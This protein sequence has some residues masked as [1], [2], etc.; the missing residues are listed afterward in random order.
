MFMSY[1]TTLTNYLHR[2]LPS[3]MAKPHLDSEL[4]RSFNAIDL[5]QN[6]FISLDEFT[7]CMRGQKI[8]LSSEVIQQLNLKIDKNSDG[9]I[10]WAEYVSFYRAREKEL[11]ESFDQLSSNSSV[12]SGSMRTALAVLGIKAS[13]EEV[14]QFIVKLDGNNDGTI[15]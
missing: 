9:V 1:I 14:R 5:D 10:S 6:G 4:A 2:I 12:T 8:P 13:D 15:R 7:K 11:I 3:G